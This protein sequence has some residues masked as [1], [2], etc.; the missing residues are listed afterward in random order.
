[1]SSPLPGADAVNVLDFAQ[2]TG[3][4]AAARQN[5]PVALEKAAQQ[6]EALFTQTVLKSMREAL[7][8][9]SG[10]GAQGEFYTSMYDQQLASSMSSGKGFGLADLLIRQLGQTRNVATD[11]VST[12]PPLRAARNAAVLHK[13]KAA[14]TDTMSIQSSS[15][16]SAKAEDPSASTSARWKPGDTH[17]FIDAI[18]PYAEKAARALGVPVRGILA[19]AALETGWGR[20]LAR[21][22]QGRPTLNLFGIKSGGRWQGNSVE[23]Q[24]SEFRDGAFTRESAQFRS[25]DSLDQAFDD[26]VS[27]LSCNPRYVEALRADNVH[28]F[29]HGLQK[30][31]YATDP[32]YARKLVN[33]ANG[34]SMNAALT[35]DDVA[36]AAKQYAV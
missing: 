20:H 13:D 25:Y 27:F 31:G 10:L 5:D 11:P 6:F 36:P 21:D 19:Q 34:R 8:G 15:G 2:Y 17:G 1:M 30:A 33:V 22:E 4:R 23:S 16:A 7:P 3:L 35:R 26:Y 9:D 32:A 29:A 14:S 24:T 28:E 18:R 12:Q